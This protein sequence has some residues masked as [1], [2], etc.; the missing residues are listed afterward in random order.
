MGGRGV[1]YGSY[2]RGGKRA[3]GIEIEGDRERLENPNTPKR[4]R[5]NRTHTHTH[6]HIQHTHLNSLSTPKHHK[7]RKY[8]YGGRLGSRLG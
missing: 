2:M 4:T 3:N 1:V 5:H 6:T 8:V 7:A